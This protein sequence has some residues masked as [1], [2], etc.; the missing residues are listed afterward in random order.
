[1]FEITSIAAKDTFD[2]ELL[3]PNDEPLKDADGAQLRVCR[4]KMQITI[5][6][7][8]CLMA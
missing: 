1:M 5:I 2:V 8:S 3:S 6:A 4:G 7:M